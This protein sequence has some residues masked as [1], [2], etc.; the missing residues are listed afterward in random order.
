[1]TAVDSIPDN[2]RQFIEQ[3]IDDVPQLETLLMMSE[4]PGRAWIVPEV[5]ARNYISEH[6]AGEVLDALRRRNLVMLD[7]NGFRFDPATPQ[8]RELVK[9]V[10]GFYRTNISRIAN[11]IH[12]KPS[13]SITEFARAFDFKKER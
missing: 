2:V 13:A 3:F 10:A 12:T 5:A 4:D 9:E 7:S 6:R 11:L 1:M 8:L